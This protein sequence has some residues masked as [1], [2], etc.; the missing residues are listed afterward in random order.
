MEITRN[1]QAENII[2]TEA[3]KEQDFD[4]SE[5]TR[6][7][8]LCYRSPEEVDSQI[9]NF[10]VAINERKEV[11]GCV[12]SKL[13]GLNMEIISLMTKKEFRGR[14]LGTI[15]L[16][17][18]VEELRKWDS[19]NIFALTTENVAIKLFF[20]LGFIEVGIQLFG[21]KVLTDCLG[22]S[23]NRMKEGVHLCNEIAVLY[24][25]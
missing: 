6:G 16:Q 12:G 5:L 18:K 22:C 24:Q 8:N 21:P 3:S 4:I 1:G 20:P 17:R 23:K 2:I 15:L 13:Y 19:L 11:I 9:S 14:G 7:E 10:L 25:R